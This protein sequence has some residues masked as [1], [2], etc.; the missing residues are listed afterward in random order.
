MATERIRA[1]SAAFFVFNASIFFNFVFLAIVLHEIVLLK[2][3]VPVPYK[4]R[5]VLS[6]DIFDF[7]YKHLNINIFLD[8]MQTPLDRGLG[9][10]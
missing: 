2:K 3:E 8:K 7:W 5:I 6:Y 9:G 4:S 10:F 1:A